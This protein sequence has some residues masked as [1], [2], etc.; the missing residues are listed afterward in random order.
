VARNVLI[1]L[2]NP[3]D[4]ADDAFNEWYDA[5]HIPQVLDVP[6]VVA[7]QRYAI[8][9]VNFPDDPNLPAMPPPPA[10][11]YMVIYEL[12]REPDH[13]MQEFL[14]RTVAGTLTLG[15]TLDLS[16]ISLTGWTPLGARRVPES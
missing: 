16:T 5:T 9:E 2:S 11:R 6:G 10:H 7:A 13:V 14:A 15:E 3:I 12:D 4:E 8:S 1:V